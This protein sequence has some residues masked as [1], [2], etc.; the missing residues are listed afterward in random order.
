MRDVMTLIDRQP[1][2]HGIGARLDSEPWLVV[3]EDEGSGELPTYRWHY[4]EAQPPDAEVG[5]TGYGDED[6]SRRGGTD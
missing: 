3:E 2:S 6:N 4:D 5:M 1:R